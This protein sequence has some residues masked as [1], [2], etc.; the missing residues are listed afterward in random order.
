MMAAYI[1][2]YYLET[3]SDRTL[4]NVCKFNYHKTQG[5]NAEMHNVHFIE[6][7][8]CLKAPHF[9]SPIIALVKC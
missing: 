5:K 4:C 6:E 3:F 7:I 9:Y 1:T 2:P 8:T